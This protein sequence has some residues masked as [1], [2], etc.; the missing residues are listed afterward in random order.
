M[1]V[2]EESVVVALCSCL[3]TIGPRYLRFSRSISILQP[4]ELDLEIVY[5]Q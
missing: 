2:A 4:D 5:H 3:L 1:L